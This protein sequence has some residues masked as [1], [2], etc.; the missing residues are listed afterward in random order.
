V[1]VNEEN[2]MFEASVEVSLK[3]K[4]TNDGIMVAIYVGVDTVHPLKYLS[5]HAGEGFWEWHA[6]SA[7]EHSFVVNIALDPSHQVF[8]ISWRWHFGW[9]FVI[10]RILPEIL[11]SAQVLE[12]FGKWEENF[13]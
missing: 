7:G 4:L 6:D 3:A 13:Y 1:L 10:L 11:E 12:R 8:D 2:V 5:D 9:P